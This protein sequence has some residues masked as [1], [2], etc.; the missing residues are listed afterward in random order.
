MKEIYLVRHCQADGQMP[1]AK[2]TELGLEQAQSL[3]RFFEEVK[4]DKIY[5]STYDRAIK[6][7]EPLAEKNALAIIEDERLT[8]R[9]FTTVIKEDW[10]ETF[11][12]GF[13]NPDLVFEGGESGKAA[14][15]RIVSMFE[16]IFASEDEKIV[17]AS[18]GNLISLFLQTINPNFD[19]QDYMNLSNPDVFF[20]H[21]SEED[22]LSYE[23]I[24]SR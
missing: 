1:D 5:S 9:V 17:V 13:E 24:W 23:R 15:A 3:V 11:K 20:I 7:V 19:F 8:E 22:Q 21:Y 4:I 6:S 12:L 10:F 2:L 14:R 18:H 16:E